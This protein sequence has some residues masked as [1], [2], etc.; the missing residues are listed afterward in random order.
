MVSWTA[1]RGLAAIAAAAP[2]GNGPGKKGA[3]LGD[4]VEAAG[5]PA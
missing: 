4:T 5:L 2:V 1:E 3:A